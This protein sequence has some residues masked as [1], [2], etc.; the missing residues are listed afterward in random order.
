MSVKERT[1]IPPDAG[2]PPDETPAAE[3]DGRGRAEDSA[4]PRIA[5][6]ALVAAGILLM[7]LSG[8]APTPTVFGLWENASSE[9]SAIVSGIVG[10]DDLYGEPGRDVVVGGEGDDFIE[11]KDG[12]GDHISCGPGED[13]VSVDERDAVASDCETVY[14]S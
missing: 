10:D 6:L 4:S 3:A 8:W 12:A 5:G 9:G 14:G 2:V 13:V 11:A 7:S 1:F